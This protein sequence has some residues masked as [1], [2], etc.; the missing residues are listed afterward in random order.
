MKGFMELMHELI[1][2][3]ESQ[4][5]QSGSEGLTVRA[6]VYAARMRLQHAV[7][8]ADAIDGIREIAAN[9]MGCEEL[10]LYKVD[11]S[12][13]ALWLYW[14]FGIDP[15]TFAVLDAAKEPNLTA[16]LNGSF[17]FV[18][19][20]QAGNLLNINKAVTAMVPIVVS[21]VV[22]AVLVLFRLLAQKAS[23]DAADQEL[24][25]VISGCAGRAIGP[26]NPALTTENGHARE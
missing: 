25:R 2:K 23:F 4:G 11:H 16:V 20:D 7:D 14:S 3:L 19:P 10:A 5:D 22:V 21:D 9:L 13:A 18:Q 6:K 12:Q 26:S 24:C 15:N 17:A 8:Q 1:D